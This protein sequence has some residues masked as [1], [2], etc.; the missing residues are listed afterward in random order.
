MMRRVSWLLLAAVLASCTHGAR[1]PAAARGAPAKASPSAT[2]TP[3]LGPSKLA[4]M[5]VA[6]DAVPGV[7]TL[8]C[9]RGECE[10]NPGA[11]PARYLRGDANG[12]MLFETSSPP[13]AAEVVVRTT[14]GRLVARGTMRPGTT[15]AFATKLRKARFVVTLLANWP[16]ADARWVFGVKGP[17]G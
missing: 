4:R 14:A 13:R 15:M 7:V 6:T 12:V 1:V 3:V 11:R 10:R 9:A 17:A 5:A 8:W 16:D 2:P